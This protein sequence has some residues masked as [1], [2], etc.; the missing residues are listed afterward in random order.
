MLSEQIE[1]HVKEEEQRVEGM[2]SQ[3]KTAGVDMDALGDQL[4]ARK[5]ELIATYK[6]SGLP[7]PELTTMEATT[8]A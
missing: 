8:P 4:A 2:F 6:K 1:H 3:A 5:A 7:R